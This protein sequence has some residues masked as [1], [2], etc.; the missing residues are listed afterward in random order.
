[1]SRLKA[2]VSSTVHDLEEHR[3]EV[4]ALCQVLKVESRMMEHL[5]ASGNRPVDV[6]EELVEG[7]DVYIGVFGL[8]YG[9]IP[10]GDTISITERELLKAESCGLEPLIFLS[11]D[12][13]SW[14]RGDWEE[15][16]AAKKL[17]QLRARLARDYICMF[18]DSPKDLRVKVSEALH[19]VFAK[20]EKEHGGAVDE[21]TEESLRASLRR[22]ADFDECMKHLRWLNELKTIHDALHRTEIECYKPIRVYLDASES[23]HKGRFLIPVDAEFELESSFN[24]LDFVV[25]KLQDILAQSENLAGEQNWVNDLRDARD[26]LE[27]AIRSRDYSEVP[28]CYR[29]VC[30]ILIRQPERLNSRLISEA[31][32]F[33]NSD[34]I[35][36]LFEDEERVS[37]AEEG[38]QLREILR[39]L[40][41][42]VKEHDAWQ[43]MDYE[44]RLIQYQAV[45]NLE[46]SWP[47]IRRQAEIIYGV[48]VSG[49]PRPL[50]QVVEALELPPEQRNSLLLNQQ[51]LNFCAL[52]GQHFDKVDQSLRKTCRR[53]VE[54]FACFGDESVRDGEK[55][56]A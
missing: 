5:T 39:Q 43:N 24:A 53:A 21:E 16:P 13:H 36:R 19:A 32:I 41:K 8:R 15:G 1:M 34:L 52:A 54:A 26:R 56:R 40:D 2:V 45:E 3:D 46:D 6:S 35:E 28:A 49:W 17:Q 7:A 10:E 48:D 38:A 50:A 25:L 44:L 4:M 20:R 37:A 31:R 30:R 22:R 12:E 18:F 51:F 29:Q 33:R 55:R 14:K 42:Y 9:Y 27:P 11:S 23:Q 47:E